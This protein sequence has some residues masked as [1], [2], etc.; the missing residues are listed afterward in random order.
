MR[1]GSLKDGDKSRELEL[2]LMNFEQQ[3]KQK[4][5]DIDKLKND[6]AEK[7]S[8]I[9]LLTETFESE[10]EKLRLENERNV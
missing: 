4:D 1:N 3:I 5:F 6:L 8:D 7:E 9:A 2:K 10:Y